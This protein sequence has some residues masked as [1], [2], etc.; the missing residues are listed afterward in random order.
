[1]AGLCAIRRALEYNCEVIAFEQAR[2]AKSAARGFIEM[3]AMFI[4]P[5]T[6]TSQPTFPRK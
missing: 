5:C 1:V 4:L 3:N 2:R 6:K